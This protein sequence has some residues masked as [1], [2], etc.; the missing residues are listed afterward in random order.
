ML[1][2]ESVTGQSYPLN[3]QVRIPFQQHPVLVGARLHLIAIADQVARAWQVTR[4]E[5]PFLPGRKAGAPAT[6]Q[7]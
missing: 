1:H 6:A 4:H 7:P 2:P 3:Q 5:R